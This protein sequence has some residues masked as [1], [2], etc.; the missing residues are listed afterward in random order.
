MV[1]RKSIKKVL[2]KTT[3]DEKLAGHAK[4]VLEKTTVD[5]VI[6]RQARRALDSTTLDDRFLSAADQMRHAIRKNI[7]TA[8]MAAFGIMIALV[9]RDV[10]NEAINET[11]KMLSIPQGGFTFQIVSAFIVT[12][13]CIV[14][15]A[16]FSRW[17]EKK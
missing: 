2:G 14:G 3:L 16:Y 5:D 11:V 4:R 15:I 13:V 8:V 17:S 7:T 6:A 1:V 10:V 9:W 12:V